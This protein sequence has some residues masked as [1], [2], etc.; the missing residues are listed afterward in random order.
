MV[1]KTEVGDGQTLK[2]KGVGIGADDR[3]A[4]QKGP[5]ETYDLEKP[6]L[7]IKDI[8]DALSLVVQT[9][10]KLGQTESYDL[11]LCNKCKLRC[12]GKWR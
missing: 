5:S 4:M 1:I 11:I 9:A 3:N 12:R 8:M 10:E 7:T 2:P 6:L